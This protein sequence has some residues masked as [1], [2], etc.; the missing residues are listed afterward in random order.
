MTHHE[1]N[2]QTEPT[3]D[4]KRRNDQPKPTDRT[5]S[6]STQVLKDMADNAYLSVANEP[7]PE[8]PE[9]DDPASAGDLINFVLD[10]CLELT[11]ALYR[12]ATVRFEEAPIASR[13][14]I[15]LASTLSNEVVVWVRK[16][17]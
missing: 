3:T 15:E 14:A 2:D 9:S 6:D 13:R 1:N 17:K 5:I 16:W 12:Y 11:D 4:T 7:R 8:P 10:R